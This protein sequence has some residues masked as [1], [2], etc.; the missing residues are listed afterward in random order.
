MELGQQYQAVKERIVMSIAVLAKIPIGN[1]GSRVRFWHWKPS[2]PQ[3][4]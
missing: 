4:K 2:F 3:V 1:R